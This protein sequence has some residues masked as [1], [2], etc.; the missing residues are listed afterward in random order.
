MKGEG[1][2]IKK[3]L[4]KSP[5]SLQGEVHPLPAISMDK[6]LTFW[7]NVSENTRK[8]FIKFDSACEIFNV[9]QN[10]VAC[11][12]FISTLKEYVSELFYSLLPGTIT[13]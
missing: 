11:R 4:H 8:H 9:A 1:I 5:L 13:S 7:K 12:L 3:R 2:Q 6:F 10:D